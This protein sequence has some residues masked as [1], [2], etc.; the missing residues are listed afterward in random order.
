MKEKRE[1]KKHEMSERR[2]AKS[3]VVKKVL[4]HIKEDDKDFRK[5]I[6]DDKVLAKTLKKKRG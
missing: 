5:Q 4:S 3:G 6:R 2:S 1:S